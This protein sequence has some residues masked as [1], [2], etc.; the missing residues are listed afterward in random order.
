MLMQGVTIDVLFRKEIERIG[1]REG[2]RAFNAF[3]E[4]P[5]KEFGHYVS[6]CECG[7]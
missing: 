3:D 5:K 1:V 4:R 7:D 6:D 2:K